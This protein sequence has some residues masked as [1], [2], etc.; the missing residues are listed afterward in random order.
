MSD[1]LV[2][3]PRPCFAHHCRTAALIEVGRYLFFQK[4]LAGTG[5][6][7]VKAIQLTREAIEEVKKRI[8]FG[9]N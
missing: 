9:K 8:A 2:F 7:Y 5:S 6:H 1:A 4:A 3:S